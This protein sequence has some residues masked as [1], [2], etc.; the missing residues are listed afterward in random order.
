MVPDKEWG[1]RQRMGCQSQVGFQ[2]WDDGI[3]DIDG[4]GWSDNINE[5]PK[6]NSSLF[7]F[8]ILRQK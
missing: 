8:H 1:S 6:W 4:Q 2:T 5:S 3:P 7:D